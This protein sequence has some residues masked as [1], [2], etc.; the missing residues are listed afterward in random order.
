MV[1]GSLLTPW[2]LADRMEQNLT[3]ILLL[4]KHRGGEVKWKKVRPPLLEAYK[5]FIDYVLSEIAKER[6]WFH[7]MVLKTSDF[8]HARFNK[9][10]G[11][12]ASTNSC[13]TIC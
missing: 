7:A 2:N 5:E 3:S 11:N 6:I 8:N 4:A 1:I 10:D 13:T 12:S 9:G